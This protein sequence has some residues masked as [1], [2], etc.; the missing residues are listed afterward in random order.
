MFP[1][2]DTD[3]FEIS[4]VARWEAPQHVASPPLPTPTVEKI[5]PQVAKNLRLLPGIDTAP[6]VSAVTQPIA[7][8]VPSASRLVRPATQRSSRLVRVSMPPMQRP[9]PSPTQTLRP[10]APPLPP[11][12]EPAM[13]PTE[14]LRD[15]VVPHPPTQQQVKPFTCSH[16]VWFPAPTHCSYPTADNL[17]QGVVLLKTMT[18]FMLGCTAL[19][20]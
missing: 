17:L 4:T 2:A 3:R 8:A 11:P 7:R 15:A 12:K 10:A 18:A 5:E 19:R 1:A 14:T 6:T 16:F 13:A 9:T 20:R